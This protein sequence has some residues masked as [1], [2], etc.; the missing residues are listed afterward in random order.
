MYVFGVRMSTRTDSIV[1]AA[2][3]VLWRYGAVSTEKLAC[4]IVVEGVDMPTFFTGLLLAWVDEV[5]Q[6]AMRALNAAIGVLEEI[7]WD[8]ELLKNLRKLHRGELRGDMQ[9]VADAGPGM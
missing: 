2:W 8:L 5:E 7:E 9:V 1:Y 4:A 3:Q 6:H